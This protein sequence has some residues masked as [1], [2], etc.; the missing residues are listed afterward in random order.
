[1]ETIVRKYISL[2]AGSVVIVASDQIS[3]KLVE[4]YFFPFQ[5]ITVIKG[6]LNLVY[7][8]NPGGAFGLFSRMD[9]AAVFPFFLL[10]T[11]TAMGVIIYFY[12]K[13]PAHRRFYRYAL[14]F[15][16]G[17]ALGN[18]IDRV[19]LG[20]VVDFLDFH[21]GRYH[22]PAFNVADACITTGAIMF[23]ITLVRPAGE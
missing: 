14:T 5:S 20:Q 21:L 13:L 4:A 10:I 17:G 6:F 15:I 7:V 8:R 16:L 1:M 23:L 9:P 22:W 19:R 3:K 18:F 12:G 11:I 2:L